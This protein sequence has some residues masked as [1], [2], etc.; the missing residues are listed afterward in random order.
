VRLGRLS[1]GVRCSCGLRLARSWDGDSEGEDEDEGV[2]VLLR[3]ADNAS[4]AWCGGEWCGDGDG[5]GGLLYRLFYDT[6]IR[7]YVLL[8]THPPSLRLSSPL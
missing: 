7:Y 8:Y 6:V 3:R 4:L 5:D 1:R 2:W